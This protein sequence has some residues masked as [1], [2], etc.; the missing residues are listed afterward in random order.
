[1]A[2][3][4][5]HAARGAQ[6]LDRHLGGGRGRE[7]DVHHVPAGGVQSG[8]RG[9]SHQRTGRA[10]IA[11][12]DDGAIPRKSP[13]ERGGEARRRSRDRVQSPTMPRTPATLIMKTT[14]HTSVRPTASGPEWTTAA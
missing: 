12:E 5:D 2:G 13:R 8:A 3:G 9:Q 6:V 11:A 14:S 7:P 10:R 4:E 1:V